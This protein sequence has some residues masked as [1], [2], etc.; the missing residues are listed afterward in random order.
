MRNYIP[1][2]LSI[3]QHLFG[4][5]S[6]ERDEIYPK[7][8]IDLGRMRWREGEGIVCMRRRSRIEKG[9]ETSVVRVFNPFLSPKCSLITKKVKCNVG[10]NE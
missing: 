10:T 3:P 7:I 9:L 4:K 2:T 6:C 8:P 1:I 5:K